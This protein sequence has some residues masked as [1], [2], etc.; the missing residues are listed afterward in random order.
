MKGGK[1]AEQVK[2]P[3]PRR[4]A[5]NTWPDADRPREK[6]IRRGPSSLTDA[7]LLAILLRAGSGEGS[8]YDLALG[9]LQ[10]EGDLSSVAR[11]NPRELMRL[12]GIGPAKAAGLVAAFEIGRRLQA[13]HGR[14]RPIVRT[15]EDVAA[16]MVPR[17]RDLACEVF[18]VLALD[19]ANRIVAEVELSRGTLN[20][21]I[22][23]PREVFKSAID[24]LAASII[25]V[26]NH[27]SGNEEPSPEDAAITRQLAEA[28]RLLGIPLHDHIIVAGNRS[29][30]L[31]GR[32]LL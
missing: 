7:E 16:F 29:T 17:L 14:R 32:G 4:G 10:R 12:R 27:P 28:G 24:N 9:L 8:A 6:L 19:S 18:V 11:R 26:H 22:V 15:P 23:H 20:A 5:I 31:A 13:E 25:V 3:L 1:C 2:E 21:S 30:S